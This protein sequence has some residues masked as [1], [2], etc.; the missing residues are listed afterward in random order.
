LPHNINIE[1]MEIPSIIKLLGT[2]V[3]ESIAL[4]L[5]GEIPSKITIESITPIPS[6][7]LLKTNIPDVLEVKGIPDTIEVIGFPDFIP[8]K[9]PDNAEIEMVYKGSPIEVK[10]DLQPVVGD[11]GE[12][13]QPCFM[14][15]PCNR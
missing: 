7:I 13:E 11:P 8:L 10:V 9:M 15:T 4:E 5:D 12:G 6:E 2:D 1:G 3:P 14:L